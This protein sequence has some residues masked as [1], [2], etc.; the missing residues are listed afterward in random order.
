MSPVFLLA[1]LTTPAT[2]QRYRSQL[3]D[4]DGDGFVDAEWAEA[5]GDEFEDARPDCDDEDPAIHPDAD[6]IPYNGVD[7]D[8]SELTSDDDVDGDGFKALQVGG[9]DCDDEDAAVNPDADEV[10]YDG[11]D[12]DCDG[13]DDDQDGDELPLAE[14]CDD[15]DPDVGG[16][17]TRYEDRDEDGY[18][19]PTS[20]VEAC[21]GSAGVADDA[22]DCDDTNEFVNPGMDEVCG[23]GADNDCSVGTDCRWS[24]GPLDEHPS[25]EAAPGSWL[26]LSA[27]LDTSGDGRANIAATAAGGRVVGLDSS[28]SEIWSVN[29]S[30]NHIASADQNADGKADLLASDDGDVHLFLDIAQETVS[31]T[32]SKAGYFPEQVAFVG[33]IDSGPYSD[34]AV[35]EPNAGE[36]EDQGMVWLFLSGWSGYD[37]QIDLDRADVVVVGSEASQ[38]IGSTM[39]G[40]DLVADGQCDLVVAARHA[41]P[42]GRSEAGSVFVFETP[43]ADQSSDEA[44][45]AVHGLTTGDNLGQALHVVDLDLDGYEEL[46]VS[47]V[48]ADESA[49]DAG[50]VYVFSGPLEGSLTAD[51]AVGVLA[52]SRAYEFCGLSI[53]TLDSDGDGRLEVA[54]G[55]PAADSFKGAVVIFTPEL[56]ATVEPDLSWSG[57]SAGGAAGYALAGRADFDGDGLDDLW[58]GA[59][60]SGELFFIPGSG[61]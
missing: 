49:T 37:G 56:G 50:A 21:A 29:D 12:D 57:A 46:L 51:D 42:G 45:A 32:F 25:L 60:Q 52:C 2:F 31:A 3:L 5:Y 41:N 17:S 6:E 47:A 14:D 61:P 39:A 48:G 7:E 19:D 26:S 9:D 23:D 24:S 59:A 30:G 15:T 43:A 4:S 34:I 10:W 13:R 20:P 53:A 8:C 33:T 22:T 36:L 1:C 11:L 44:D 18:G 54:V 55:A 35:A 28:F 38:A 58:V 27:T 16:P 40:L